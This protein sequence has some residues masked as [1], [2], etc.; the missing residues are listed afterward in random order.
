MKG[1]LSP[2]AVSYTCGFYSIPV[3]GISSRHSS[4][5][6]KV[7][8]MSCCVGLHRFRITLRFSA[9]RNFINGYRLK[10]LDDD[11]AA[12]ASRREY[13]FV[14]TMQWRRQHDAYDAKAS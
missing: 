8:R 13:E 11:I 14:P 5:S 1:E 3:I 10:F 2:A 4:L 9:G 12:E 6:D 7:R